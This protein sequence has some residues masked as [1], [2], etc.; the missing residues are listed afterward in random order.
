[1]LRGCLLEEKHLDIN[2]LKIK[3]T[4]KYN[5]REKTDYIEDIIF[6]PKLKW[7]MNK[8]RQFVSPQELYIDNLST[9]YDIESEGAKKLIE[10]LRIK[11]ENKNLTP[12]EKR[13]I[14]IGK[15]FDGLTD[16]GIKKLIDERNKPVFPTSGVYPLGRAEKIT[17]EYGNA[18][19]ITYQKREVSERVSSPE[20]DPKIYLESF[21]KNRDEKLV[22]QICKNEMPLEKK[23][24]V[25]YFEKVEIFSKTSILTKESERAY[26]C[27]CPICAAKYQYGGFIDKAQKNKIKEKILNENITQNKDGNY[28]IP[29]SLDEATNICF[30]N[31]H[32][33]DLKT[34][35]EVENK[36]RHNPD[37]VVIE[38]EPIVEKLDKN[39][40]I[41]L[42]NSEMELDLNESNTKVSG[43]KKENKIWWLSIKD[44][45]FDD[46]FHLMSLTGGKSLAFR[47]RL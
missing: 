21:Y 2:A 39:K 19:S 22:C 36:I 10:F 26:I 20:I 23:N 17:E 40:A 41:N 35:L 6:Y 47:R 25:Y 18:K 34:I 33:M 9:D 24:G 14:E 4:Y 12:E 45:K 16:D 3:H 8:N 42:V 29:I 38:D 7:L 30:V 13:L 43:V 37:A 32:F 46:D 5:S 11:E 31:K 44:S 15:M 28:E 27:C 1:M